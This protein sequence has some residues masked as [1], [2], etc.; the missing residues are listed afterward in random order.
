MRILR[1]CSLVP[2]SHCIDEVAK[3]DEEGEDAG[4]SRKT[5]EK[6]NVCRDGVYVGI[7]KKRER[8]GI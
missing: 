5:T 6:V 4:V 2:G 8:R 7:Q 3:A 1:L